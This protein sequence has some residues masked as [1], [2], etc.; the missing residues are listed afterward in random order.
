MM[1][2]I[3]IICQNLTDHLYFLDTQ[4]VSA[5]IDYEKEFFCPICDITVSFNFEKQG[6]YTFKTNPTNL[7][8]LVSWA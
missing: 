4:K 7:K 8:G 2:K 6:T 1:G 3:G 5:L